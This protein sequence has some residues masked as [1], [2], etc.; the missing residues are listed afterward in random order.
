[1]KWLI[2]TTCDY[3]LEVKADTQEEAEEKAANTDMSN[4]GHE[5]DEY[6]TEMIS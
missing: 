5:W 4:W 6:E 3:S 1:M 2:R